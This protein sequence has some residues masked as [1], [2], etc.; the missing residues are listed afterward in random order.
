MMGQYYMMEEYMVTTP[1]D[2]LRWNIDYSDLIP[3]NAGLVMSGIIRGRFR[4]DGKIDIF[5]E[6]L[7]YIRIIN[8]D[9]TEKTINGQGS[10]R[11]ITKL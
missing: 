10:E 3:K 1:N 11:I 6:D 9:E 7:K 8:L 5:P 2:L 4:E